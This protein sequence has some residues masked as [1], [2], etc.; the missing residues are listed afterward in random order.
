MAVVWVT[1][2]PLQFPA[3]KFGIVAPINLRP[4]TATGVRPVDVVIALAFAAAAVAAVASTLEG[5]G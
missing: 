4:M 2:L 5:G 1:P 3:T